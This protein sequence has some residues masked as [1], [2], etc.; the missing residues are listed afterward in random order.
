MW[1]RRQSDTCH[2]RR[3]RAE[4][5]QRV[6]PPGKVTWDARAV[7]PEEVYGFDTHGN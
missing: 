3:T 4:R 5:L 2:S 7:R 6:F 1:N